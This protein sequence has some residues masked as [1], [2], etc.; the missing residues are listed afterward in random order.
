M[1]F[2]PNKYVAQSQAQAKLDDKQSFDPSAYVEKNDIG[3]TKSFALGAAQGV[4]FGFADELAGV[5]YAVKEALK[6]RNRDEAYTEGR[7]AARKTF[8]QAEAANPKAFVAGELISVTLP[9]GAIAKGAG[10]AGRIGRA[11]LGGAATGAGMSE[12]ETPTELAKD[13]ATGAALGGG[14]AGLLEFVGRKAAAIAPEKLRAYASERAVKASGAMKG[15][16]NRIEKTIG[17]ENLGRQLIEKKVVTPFASLETVSERAGALREK[18]GEAIGE[19][20]A[21]VDDLVKKAKQ[22]LTQAAIP[23]KAKGQ[24][25]KQ[26]DEEFQ[27]STQQIGKRIENELIKPNLRNPSGGISAANLKDPGLRGEMDKLQAL[28]ND[29]KQGKPITLV[30]GGLVKARQGKQTRFHSET[31]PEA[32]KQEVYSIIKTQLDNVVAKTEALEEGVSK[33][34][35]QAQLGIRVPGAGSASKAYTDAKKSYAAAKTA[36]EMALNRL[37]A[38]QS[39]RGVSLTDTIAGASGIASGGGPLTAI[40]LG[41]INKFGRQYGATMQMYG[42]EKLADILSTR[43]AVLGKKYLGPLLD[44]ATKGPA[45]LAATHGYFMKDPEYRQEI[46]AENQFEETPLT[47][48]F[49]QGEK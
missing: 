4:T 7:D 6:G 25:A 36:E 10:V 12:A 32:F 2:D 9:G 48:R 37:G 49:K 13:V 27:F 24:L 31:I 1:P 15:D 20:L 40:A 41:A 35:G 21:K 23:P 44:A 42:A 46:D 39:N 47:R 17:V 22:S 3:V 33:L 14:S 5:A 43:P 30:E 45:A 16:F 34:T 28:A 38:I 11:A 8:K 26:I 29:Y 18:S 19:A